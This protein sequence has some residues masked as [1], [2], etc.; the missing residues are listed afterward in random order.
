MDRDDKH[1]R[2]LAEEL[3]E[4]PD[5][6]RFRNRRPGIRA[7]RKISRE[8]ADADTAGIVGGTGVSGGSGGTAG[9]EFGRTE[10][11]PAPNVPPEDELDDTVQSGESFP[12]ET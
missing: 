4:H 9:A 11:R 5:D 12:R 3:A 7:S 6:P 1:A 2:E 8:E 10:G